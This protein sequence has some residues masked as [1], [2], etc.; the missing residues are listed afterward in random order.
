MTD[1]HPDFFAIEEAWWK[2]VD[3]NCPNQS[4]RARGRWMN[5]NVFSYDGTT[6]TRDRVGYKSNSGHTVVDNAVTFHGA[7]GRALSK[8]RSEFPNRRNDAKRNW[9]LGKE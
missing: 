6:W 1:I 3:E 7:D 9:G 2:W 5:S 8:P 4:S